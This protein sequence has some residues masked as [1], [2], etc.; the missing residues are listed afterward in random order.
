MTRAE[1]LGMLES[2]GVPAAYYTFPE[3]SGVQ[4]PFICFY[5]GYG[6]LIADNKPYAG[7]TPLTV[8]L[9]SEQKDFNLEATVESI[10][11][12]A[13]IVFDKDETFIESENMF[14]I[15]YTMEVLIDEC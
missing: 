11:T 1:V 10:F 5:Y 3:K 6:P 2:S 13:G 14:E 4:P 9:Y 15:I 12:D 7:I 8:E